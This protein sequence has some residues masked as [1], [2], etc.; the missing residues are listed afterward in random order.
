MMNT[1]SECVESS[2]FDPDGWLLPFGWFGP[3]YRM[4]DAAYGQRR[5]WIREVSLWMLGATVAVAPLVLL[6]SAFAAHRYGSTVLFDEP[7][8]FWSLIG[9][10][11]AIRALA[12]WWWL[13]RHRQNLER[14]PARSLGVGAR[15]EV[16]HGQATTRQVG[17]HALFMA[18]AALMFGFAFFAG[19]GITSWPWTVGPLA[20]LLG[21]D[22]VAAAGVWVRRRRRESAEADDGYEPA[23][24]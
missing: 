3:V 6:V 23:G 8:L 7:L 18:S 2:R 20:A 1:P 13:A 15:L 5:A 17:F 12:S 21:G 22:A 4:R 9:L 11:L 10:I 19:P 16:A 24:R 14:V